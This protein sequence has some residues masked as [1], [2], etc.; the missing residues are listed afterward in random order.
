ML[1][2]EQF[3]HLSTY[4]IAKEAEN[5][6]IKVKKI[7]TKGVYADGSLLEFSYK[8]R[9]EYMVG[10]RTSKT[11]SVAYWLQKNKYYAKIFLKKAGLSVSPGEIFKADDLKGIS[12]Y[13][14]KV[15]YPVVA[16][17]TSGTHGSQVYID[18]RNKKALLETVKNFSS[19]FLIEKMFTGTEYRMFVT[20]HQFVAAT[21]RIPANVVGD[22]VSTVAQLVEI[23]NDD[24]RRSDG[25]STGLVNL[26]LDSYTDTV[27]SKQGLTKRSVPKTG[28][29]VFLRDNS[30]LSTGGDSI[31]VTDIVHPDVKKIAVQA[32]QAIPGL[33]YGGVDFLTNKNIAEK[34][35]SRSYVIIEIN[36]SPM[37]SM[38]HHPYIGKSRDAASAIVDTMFP[39]TKNHDT[40]SRE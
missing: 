16:K 37:I 20:R 25:Y 5:R 10:Q 9:V 30:N 32:V 11:D 31:D 19:N 39:G 28:Q 2:P 33:A 29:I 21:Q 22:G 15:G 8:D 27:L 17:K 7:V 4:L 18:I 38:H 35:N 36:D 34:P 1:K 14:D 3:K 13:A 6:G 26:K 24:P 40:N 23:K 12:E